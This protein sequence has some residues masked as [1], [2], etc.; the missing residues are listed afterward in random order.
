MQNIS[1]FLP[2]V[3]LT[4]TDIINN[5]ESLDNAEDL[6]FVTNQMRALTLCPNCSGKRSR[7]RDKVQYFTLILYLCLYMFLISMHAY[8]RTFFNSFG[9]CS[10]NP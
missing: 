6:L 3:N 5:L 7:R 2:N 8:Y 9:V 4:N 10:D 1:C